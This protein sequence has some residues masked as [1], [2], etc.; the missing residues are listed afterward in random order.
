MLQR[1]AFTKSWLGSKFSCK[2][3]NKNLTDKK[4]FFVDILM[5]TFPF[6]KAMLKGPTVM[7]IVLSITESVAKNILVMKI[8]NI[9]SWSI[10][11]NLMVTGVIKD[12]PSDSHF[13]FWF[14]NIL[15][16]RLGGDKDIVRGCYGFLHLCKVKPHTNIASFTKD[17]SYLP[18]KWFYRKK[19]N[20]YY[21]QP[22]TGIH[23]SSKS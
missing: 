1:G 23:L 9:A 11:G 10:P 14:C 2:Y 5:F 7:L 4:I 8:Q 22:L 15:R 18:T 6:I 13:S 21:T 20:I 3:N 17:T 19:K 12:I 16:N